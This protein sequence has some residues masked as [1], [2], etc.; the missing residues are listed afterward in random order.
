[1]FELIGKLACA[2]A[3]GLVIWDIGSHL[4]RNAWHSQAKLQSQDWSFMDGVDAW[5]ASMHQRAGAVGKHKGDCAVLLAVAL[6]GIATE[7][8]LSA[9]GAMTVLVG[10]KVAHERLKPNKKPQSVAQPIAD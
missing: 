2:L 10:I 6:L 5:R 8:L 9:I 1:M 4:C 3:V 7:Q